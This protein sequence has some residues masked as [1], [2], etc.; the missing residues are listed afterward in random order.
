MQLVTEG[1]S[2][3]VPVRI[4]EDPSQWSQVER[5]TVGSDSKWG[6]HSPGE[7]TVQG[8]LCITLVLWSMY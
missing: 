3:R 6:C 1:F 8:Q 5:L 2:S 7:T 4:P